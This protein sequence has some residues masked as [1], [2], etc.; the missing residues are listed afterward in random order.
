[1][2]ERTVM[3]RLWTSAVVGVAL[4]LLSVS[5]YSAEQVAPRFP[6]TAQPTPGIPQ[7][8]VLSGQGVVTVSG[9]L[10]V[11]PCV[12][13][14]WAEE[15]Q[16]QAWFAEPARQVTLALEGCGDGQVVGILRQGAPFPARAEWGDTRERFRIRLK[17]GVNYLTL[18]VP[19]ISGVTPLEVTYE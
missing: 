17:N 14:D 5:G 11:S 19:R 9:R 12:L 8:D 10:L 1:M 2:R 16:G 4:C 13:S 15:M 7:S 18:S 6:D 3:H